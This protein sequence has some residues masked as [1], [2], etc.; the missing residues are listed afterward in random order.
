MFERFRQR[1]YELENIDKG[2]YTPE[3]Y[4]GCLVE[5]R[6]VNEWLGDANALRGSLLK[7]IERRDLRS[8][9]VLDVGAGSGELLRV[10]AKWARETNRAASLIGLE[11]NQRSAQAIMEASVG[12]SEI[13]AVQSNGLSLPFRDAA[14]DFVISSLTLHHFDDE[15]AVNL[16]REMGRVSRLGVFVIDLHRNPTAY[17]F[18]TTLGRL[19]LHN[20]LIRED[21]ALS[22]LKS[23]VPAELE[24]LGR[25]AGLNNVSVE[26]HFPSR[27]VLSGVG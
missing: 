6:R 13:A 19:F 14:I 22:I 20:R 17:F 11:L 16:L 27:L 3:E 10:A 5:L 12:F 1:S 26:K 2:T 7:E 21:G 25:Q 23:F 15:G 8:F 18:Y 4:E 24:K 9:S